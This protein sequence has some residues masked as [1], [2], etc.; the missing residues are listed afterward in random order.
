MNLQPVVLRGSRIVFKTRYM[1]SPGMI[2]YNPLGLERFETAIRVSFQ[3]NALCIAR[4]SRRYTVRVSG[5]VWERW[6]TRE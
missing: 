4:L 3:R 1:S 2:N 5:W 6:A